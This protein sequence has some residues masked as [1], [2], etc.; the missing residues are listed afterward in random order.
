[1]HW[2]YRLAILFISGSFNSYT[3]TLN[4]RPFFNS[5]NLINLNLKLYHRKDSFLK[6]YGTLPIRNLNQNANLHNKSA[7]SLP[8]AKSKHK[9]LWLVVDLP[10]TRLMQSGI[11]SIISAEELTMTKKNSVFDLPI[12]YHK[13]HPKQIFNF[14]LNRWHSLGYARKEDMIEVGQKC[15]SFKEWISV[16]KNKTPTEGRWPEDAIF[17]GVH[18]YYRSIMDMSTINGVL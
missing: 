1:M 9:T 16:F 18:Y 11:Q 10:P 5:N 2:C 13:F 14:Q 3:F 4:L 7:T 15:S 17:R 8:K 12:G 6:I